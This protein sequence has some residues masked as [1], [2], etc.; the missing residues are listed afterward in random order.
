MFKLVHISVMPQ[1]CHPHA[2]MQLTLA[3]CRAASTR[4]PSARR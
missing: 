1:G 2:V 3:A 4:P